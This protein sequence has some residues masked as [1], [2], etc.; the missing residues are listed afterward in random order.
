LGYFSEAYLLSIK[1]LPD[2]DKAISLYTKSTEL[3]P[4][5]VEAYTNR[6]GVYLDK[7]DHDRAIKDYTKAIELNPASADSYSERGQVYAK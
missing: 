7:G 3:N 4:R 6:G 5:F 1:S 2:F